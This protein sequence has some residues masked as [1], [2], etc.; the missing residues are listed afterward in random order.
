MNPYRTNDYGPVNVMD[1]GANGACKSDDTAAI[2]AA[3]DAAGAGGGVVFFPK[4]TFK[5]SSP[6]LVR[7]SR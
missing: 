4:G 6:L 3:I 7:G 5:I 2:Q 1:F